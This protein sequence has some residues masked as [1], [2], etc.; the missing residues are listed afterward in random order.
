MKENCKSKRTGTREWSEYSLNFQRGC[1]H[2][3][4]YCYARWDDVYRY[5]RCRADEWP[6]PVINEKKVD[7]THRKK[8]PGVIMFPTRHDITPANLSQ[9]MCVLRKV[10]DAG[11]RVLIVSKPHAECIIPICRG[12]KEHQS[13]MEFRFTIGSADNDT[14]KFWEPEAPPFMERLM[15]L[16]GAFDAGYATSVSCEPYLDSFPQHTFAA[17]KPYITDS[18]WIGKLNNFN[19]RVKMA[20]VSGAEITKYIDPLKKAMS[21]EFVLAM[22]ELLKGEKLIRWKDSVQ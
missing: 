7:L 21:D 19:S 13:N 18:F 1:E 15:C 17:C 11:N 9:Y 16:Q 22:V 8:Y 20:G 4:R 12:F 5:K 14:L 6:L 2:G 10:L 3:C